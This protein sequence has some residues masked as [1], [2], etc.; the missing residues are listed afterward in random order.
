MLDVV[1]PFTGEKIESL[2]THNM[3]ELQQMLTRAHALFRERSQ[4]LSIHQR[5]TV[6]SRAAELLDERT[7]EFAT[8]I[9]REGAKPLKDARVEA[10]RAA[11]GLG[12]HDQS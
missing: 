9:A 4:W 8:L 1:S 6:L 12:H 5:A 10:S 7:E 3:D 2:A 11:E